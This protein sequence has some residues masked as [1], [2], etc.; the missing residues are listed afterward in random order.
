MTTSVLIFTFSPVQT[1]IAEARRAADLYVG[2][3]ILSELARAAAQSIGVDKL[4]Y[5][6]LLDSDVPN[7]IVARVPANADQAKQIAEGAKQALLNEWRRIAGTARDWFTKLGFTDD[8]FNDIWTR[9]IDHLWEVYWVAAEEENGYRDAYERARDALDAVKRS[10][11]FD[12]CD[13]PGVKDTLSG[14]REAMHRRGETSYRHVKGYWKTIAADARVGPSKLQSKGRERLDAIG[15]VKRFCQIANQQF[16]SVSTI[17]V[18]DFIAQAKE[19]AADTLRAYRDV[20]RSFLDEYGYEPRKDTD[21]DWPFDGDLLY[22]ETLT[23]E[24]LKESYGL[25]EVDEAKLTDVRA[26]LKALYKAVGHS[27]STYYAV[28]VLDGDGMGKRIGNCLALDHPEE[29]HRQLSL[30]LEAFA[31]RAKAIV[32]ADCLIYNGGDDVLAFLPLRH[33]VQIARDLARAF[34][35]VAEDKEAS[36]VPGTASAGIAIGHHLEPLDVALAAAREAEKQ[37]KKLEGKDAVCLTVLKRSGEEVSARSKWDDLDPLFAL[38]EHFDSGVLSSRFAYDAINSLHA[39]PLS[40]AGGGAMLT[41]ELTRQIKRHR[42]KG[43]SDAPDPDALAGQLSRWATT[44]PGGS[45]EL[46][47]WL[48]IARFLAQQRK[49]GRE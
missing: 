49:G 48:G 14:L 40:D 9:Q 24:R 20:L 11:I 10:R 13:E 45:D 25:Q 17:A 34:R 3:K 28:L 36:P 1:F 12:A 29:K 44:L 30:S 46:G 32:P 7:V 15:A 38:V 41:A 21:P 19:K 23:P 18:L 27:P 8:A 35:E 16:A 6:T 33:A 5:P 39:L 47:R 4:V 2:S 43:R 26:A 42:D 31:R 22:E 37:A